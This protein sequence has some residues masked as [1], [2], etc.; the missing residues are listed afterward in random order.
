MGGDVPVEAAEILGAGVEGASRLVAL[1][2]EHGVERGLIGPRER[3][4]LWD[5]HIV[6]SALLGELIPRDSAVVDV[7]TGAGMPGIPLALSRSDLQVTLLEP[8]A[9]R[10]R[11]LGEVLADL[12]LH[13]VTVVR[14]RAEEAAVGDYD[15]A[16]ARAV[17]PLGK[18]ARWCLPLVRDGGTLLA[19]KGASVMEELDR[20]RQAVARAGG[21]DVEI[22]RCGVGK[23]E[24]PATVVAVRKG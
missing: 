6:N 20:D 2:S 22:L 19:M 18:L 24:D 13:Q 14:A 17:A 23:V 4:R 3:E 15:V 8:M 10:V 11:W 7:G 5:R 12:E 9:R 21:E 16:T 1:L